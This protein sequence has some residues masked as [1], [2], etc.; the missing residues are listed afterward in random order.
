MHGLGQAEC[1]EYALR[2]L[3]SHPGLAGALSKIKQLYK[4]EGM[5]AYER[6]FGLW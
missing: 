2:K 6:Y 5:Q 3:Q 4:M 1:L